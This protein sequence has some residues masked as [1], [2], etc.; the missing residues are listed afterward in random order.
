[1]A[2]YSVLLLYPDYLEHQRGD[3]FYF[4][5]TASDPIEADR[6]AKSY[7][8]ASFVGEGVSD[9]DDFMTILVIAG[10]HA[11]LP[12]GTVSYGP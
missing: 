7:A 1:M 12:T 3:N 6:K 9:P 2:S 11:D 5:V 10:H 4:H 8:M